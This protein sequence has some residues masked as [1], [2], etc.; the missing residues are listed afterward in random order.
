MAASGTRVVFMGSPRFAVPSLRALHSAGYL[1]VA[2]VSQP[3][4]PAGRGGH[5]HLPEVKQAALELGIGT[6]QPA[7]LRDA[8]TVERLEAFGADVFVVAA[9]GKILPRAVLQLPKR[10]CVNVHGSLLPRWR[11]PSPIQ[12]AILAGDSETGV[13][14]MELAPEMD[15]GPVLSKV[16]FPLGPAVTAGEVE[17][18]LAA[19]GAAELTRVLPGWLSGEVKAVPQDE[20]LVTYCRLVSKADGHLAASMTAEQAERAVRAYNPWPT[21]FV[22][23][24]GDRLRIWRARLAP[25]DGEPGATKVIDR[26]PAIAFAGGWLV[27]EEVQR[28]GSRRVPGDQFL[29]GERGNLHPSVG[30][31]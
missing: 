18:V 27:L 29:N 16:P 12:A 4:R 14:I 2:A 9:Y 24:K 1:L 31:A 13:S 28:T 6:F 23:Y 20:N 3:D 19:L 25:G 11:G 21:A 7:S 10:G 26:R 8:A 22:L 15:A 30:L 5:V 17:E